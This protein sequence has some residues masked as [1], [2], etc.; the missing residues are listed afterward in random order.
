MLVSRG[1]TACSAGMGR[2][3]HFQPVFHFAV[4]NRLMLKEFLYAAFPARKSGKFLQ[5]K[6]HSMALCFYVVNTSAPDL[7]K[8]G[9]YSGPSF[10]AGDFFGAF[11]FSG[12]SSYLLFIFRMKVQVFSGCLR[13]GFRLHGLPPW[14]T[15]PFVKERKAAKA[16]QRTPLE[17]VLET[18]P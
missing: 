5:C 18:A 14:R 4:E 6:V 12:R 1:T 10:A 7:K 15:L 16:F 13:V 3:P 17:F 8:S 9:M 2:S 11:C